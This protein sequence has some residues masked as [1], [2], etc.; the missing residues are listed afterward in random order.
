[1]EDGT[2]AFPEFPVLI[3]RPKMISD[4]IISSLAD[5]LQTL[6]S[7]KTNGFQPSFTLDFPQGKF[8]KIPLPMASLHPRPIKSN[9]PKKGLN[10]EY[11]FKI[12]MCS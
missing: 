11:F 1:M 3:T 10:L 5:S 8:F 4:P 7:I 6:D 9:P 2:S 12:G